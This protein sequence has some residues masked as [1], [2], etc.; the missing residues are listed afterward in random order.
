MKALILAA[1]LGTRLAP[2]TFSLP[3]PLFTLNNR[4]VLDLAID[5]LLAAGCS[6]IFINTH[7][8]ADQ[9]H[10]HVRCHPE[11][12]R[13]QIVHE[14]KILDTGGAI[15][16]L[17]T[18]LAGSFFLVVNADIV[19]DLDLAMVIA[20]H[21][22]TN[23]L[24]TLVLHHSPAFN[25]I[26]TGPD[27]TI[28]SFWS[29]K[30]NCLAFTGLQVLS[31]EILDHLPVD[32][33]FSSID[34]Y[35][36]LC[37]TGRI[38]AFL[39]HNFF[40][41]DMGTVQR[42]QET[43]QRFLAGAHFGLNPS[44][45]NAIKIKALAGD[46]SDRQWFRAWYNNKSIILSDHGICL[47]HT[48]NR[49]QVDAFVR[50]GTHLRTNGVAVPEILGHDRISG[51]VAVQDLGSTHLADMRATLDHDDLTTLYRRV[52][53]RLV[54]FSKTGIQGFDFQ[55]ACQTPTY[56]RQMILDLE[57]RY[58]LEAFVQGYLGVD[59]QWQDLEPAFSH[60]A[61]QARARQD[62][63][64]MHRDCQSRNIMICN[65]EIFF[66]DFQSARQ[67]PLAYD[68]ASLLIDPYVTLPKA[69]QDSLLGY[70]IDQLSRR[71]GFNA[72]K[73]KQRYAYCAVARNLQMLGAF[74]FLTRVKKKSGFAR[75]IPFALAGLRQRLAK[76]DQDPVSPL[77]RLVNDL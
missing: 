22:K 20:R 60:I 75:H 13:L 5:R 7:H 23:A 50:I 66:I 55:W 40:W 62:D 43:A 35:T 77:T 76:I 71:P 49:R 29:T 42:Y 18:E 69:V 61:T 56:S 70:C 54:E 9:I 27:H 31:P 34:L 25:K 47:A 59:A 28:K 17:K 19:H 21:K 74:A 33:I 10:D 1:G 12:Q 2:Y 32:R 36:A 38:K 48:D 52:I 3:K 53:D 45:F 41:Q 4:P 67:G 37:P 30:D 57:C 63:G 46:G 65:Q 11:R 24:A 64:L 16:N 44:A 15:A 8:L 73:F 26:T 51:Q 14:P 39:A 6:R 72:R 58:F 68:L